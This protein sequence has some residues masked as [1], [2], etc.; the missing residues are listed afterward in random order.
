MSK[1]VLIQANPHEKE[2]HQG[3][4][5]CIHTFSA[6]KDRVQGL[7]AAE[8][9]VDLRVGDLGSGRNRRRSGRSLVA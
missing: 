3:R 7:L 2:R 8:E 1:K 9:A 4:A 5:H 6:T